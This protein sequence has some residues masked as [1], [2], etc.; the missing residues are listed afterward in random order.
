MMRYVRF[1]TAA[2]AIRHAI[3]TLPPLVLKG[4]V[5]QVDDGRVT[6]TSSSGSFT[7]VTLIR[8][9]AH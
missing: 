7:T 1:D 3:E 8:W 6:T 5:L 2:N 9:H 4:A